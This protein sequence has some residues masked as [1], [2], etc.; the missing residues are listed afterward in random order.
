MRPGSFAE[1][2]RTSQR[3][4]STTSSIHSRHCSAE[5]RRASYFVLQGLLNQAAGHPMAAGAAFGAAHALDPADPIAAYLTA[6]HLADE[7]GGDDMKPLVAGI[8]LLIL[9]A[10]RTW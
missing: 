7:G 6:A 1:A 3:V 4:S 2:S 5:P 10:R 9:A 8:G